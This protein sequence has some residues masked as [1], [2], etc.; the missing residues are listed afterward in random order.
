MS[1]TSSNYPKVDAT[2]D[3]YVNVTAADVRRATPRDHCNCA[4]AQAIKRAVG[5]P[6]AAAV[7]FPTVA[8]VLMPCDRGTAR[9]AF[10][11]RADVR[12]GELAWHRFQLGSD[13]TEAILRF[14]ETGEAEALGYQFREPPPSGRLEYHRKYKSPGGETRRAYTH[15][16]KPWHRER[17]F[18]LW[19]EEPGGEAPSVTPDNVHHIRPRRA[20]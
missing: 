7:I 9:A 2:A 19:H 14:D 18:R 13:L 15:K 5:R 17:D 4:V 6:D 8:Y 3:L 10:N 16:K 20:A 12:A 11:K 1:Y